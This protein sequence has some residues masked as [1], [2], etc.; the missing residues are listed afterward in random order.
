M[1]ENRWSETVSSQTCGNHKFWHNSNPT[2]GFC[3]AKVLRSR[4]P[5]V[6]ALLFSYCTD[7]AVGWLPNGGDP[8][9]QLIGCRRPCFAVCIQC[10]LFWSEVF[11]LSIIDYHS[12]SL[13]LNL[14]YTI[15]DHSC[16]NSCDQPPLNALC[17]CIWSYTK[18][19]L[20]LVWRS[21]KFLTAS[22][23]DGLCWDSHIP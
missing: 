23:S 18:E 15:P 20:K 5:L 7:A 13:K 11:Y 8:A 16:S 6:T 19:A 14:T 3:L 9:G 21:A 22:H 10:V 2:S 1:F 4:F 12:F 17:M